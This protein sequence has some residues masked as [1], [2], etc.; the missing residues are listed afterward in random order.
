MKE[1]SRKSGPWECGEYKSQQGARNDILDAISTAQENWSIAEVA[2]AHPVTFVKFNRG[3]SDY[4]FHVRPCRSIAN[5]PSV[6]LYFGPTGCG[7]TRKA[8][9][10]DPGLYSKDPSSMWFDGYHGQETLLLD[11]YSGAAS[12]MSLN[13][14]LQLLDR[15]P[16]NVQIKGG[17][18][19]MTARHIVLTT[20]LHPSVWFNY[21]KRESQYLALQRR[22]TKI[23]VFKGKISIQVSHKTFFDEWFDG[24]DQDRLFFTHADAETVDISEDEEELSEDL[25]FIGDDLQAQPSQDD[26]SWMM[27]S[28]PI[29]AF[30]FNKT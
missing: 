23:V 4:I 20:N 8:Y 1:E 2:Q 30:L 9:E 7:K 27:G 13:T 16:V 18:A 24:C 21:R 3:I 10:E 26:D 28:D 29:N 11:D 14:M 6:H 22:F 25:A 17:Y 19:K 5:P 15:F 12:K